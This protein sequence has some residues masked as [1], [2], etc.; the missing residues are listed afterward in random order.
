MKLPE[1]PFILELLPEFVDTWIIDI[2]SQYSDLVE[3]KNADDLYRMAHTLKGSCY[4]FGLDDV[5]IL[6]IELMGFA[7]EKDW[8]RALQLKAPIRKSFQDMR[9][10]LDSQPVA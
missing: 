7:K 3:T 10:F 9:D 5:A 6:G 2:D 1:D 4:Q 8:G